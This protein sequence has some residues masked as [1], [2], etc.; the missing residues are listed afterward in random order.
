MRSSDAEAFV[1]YC[2]VDFVKGYGEMVSA[3]LRIYYLGGNR[4]C[5]RNAHPMHELQESF[6][7]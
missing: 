5:L 2:G 1:I 4:L 6:D 3:L 7:L